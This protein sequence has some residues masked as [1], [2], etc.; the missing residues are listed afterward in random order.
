MRS[1]ISK[2][3]LLAPLM[4]VAPFAWAQSGEDLRLTIGK[5]VV[6]DYASDIRQISTSNPDVVDASPITTREILL[7]GK[8][9]GS[10]TMV[11]W[12][13]AGQRTFYNITVEMNLEA[14]RKLLK[15]TFPSE[16]IV[17][18]SSRDSLSLN[19][20]VSSPAVAERAVAM[21]AGF[22]K[23]VVNNLT[24]TV[25]VEKQ[26]LLRVKF[27]ELDRNAGAQYG[28]NILSTGALGGT[29]GRIGTGQF[30]SPSLTNI[31][32]NTPGGGSGGAQNGNFTISDALTMFAFRPDL[33]LAAFVK[34]LQTRG[35]LQI[36]A[37]PNL[38]TS[39]GKEAA[40]LVGGE[41]PV[42]VLQGG[43][44]AAAVTIQFKEF[45]I[46]LR[47]TPTVT[48]NKTIKLD[49]VQEVSSIDLAQGVSFNGFTIPALSTRRTQTGL[50]LGEG[51]TFL[52][53][54]LIDN[55]DIERMSRI[56]GLGQ[57]P[58]LGALFKSK[59][60]QKSLSE[61]VLMVTPEV[62]LPLNATDPK[63]MIDFPNE[64]LIPLKT[65]SSPKAMPQP[66]ASNVSTPGAVSGTASNLTSTGKKRGRK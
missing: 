33:N 49:L 22:A 54:G 41:F 27:A 66:S 64:F 14:F 63:P 45:G 20:A 34:A 24:V 31:Q 21:A 59:D 6:I 2:T 7:H 36:L 19:G 25:P 9:F 40:F 5:S 65:S 23:T 26:I 46:K 29:I 4:L 55:R 53:S 38:V 12:N 13:K 51:Q 8:G 42:P 50:E 11:V 18:A 61:L 30:G 60:V 28:V 1:T 57:I 47:F 15:D 39:N 44:T 32:P 52:V 37:E 56:P 48:P 17:I 10:A 58:I 43:A 35:V 62:T 3:A 16:D